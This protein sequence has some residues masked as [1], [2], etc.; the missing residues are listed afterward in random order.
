MDFSFVDEVR[1]KGDYYVESANQP[2]SEG[3]T[4]ELWNRRRK[5]NV[6]FAAVKRGGIEG[7]EHY[8][9]PSTSSYFSHLRTRHWN[10]DVD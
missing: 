3:N 4:L 2:I 1:R 8:E 9:K 7:D 6:S 5:R 10:I